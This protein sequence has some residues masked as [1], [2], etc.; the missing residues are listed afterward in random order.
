MTLRR[1]EPGWF[2]IPSPPPVFP[3]R[4][5]IPIGSRDAHTFT[6]SLLPHAGPVGEATVAAA[7]AL[8]DPLL[9]MKATGGVENAVSFL[10]NLP[11]MVNKFETIRQR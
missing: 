10:L 1:S 3:R 4:G 11:T 8:N 6:Y 9:V 2:A 7:Y 5:P